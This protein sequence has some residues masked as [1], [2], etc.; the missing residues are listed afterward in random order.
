[1]AA[2]RVYFFT[3]GRVRST[4][5]TTSVYGC[6]SVHLHISK[7]TRPNFMKFSTDV[8]CGHGSVLLCQLGNVLCISGFVDDVIFS[9]NGADG[10]Y[11]KTTLCFAVFTKLWHGEGAKL[12]STIALYEYGMQNYANFRRNYN[13]KTETALNLQGLCPQNTHTMGS[14]QF[15]P[16]AF[17]SPPSTI[18]FS[19]FYFFL[20][21]FLTRFI[22]FLDFPSHPI[23]PE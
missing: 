9:H 11:S 23:L 6:L 22:Y 10:A 7:I 20:F 3:T 13:Q 15:S 2:I 16:S 18:S 17:T 14:G 4:A 8:N 5:T 21:P 1:M 19:I 12:L